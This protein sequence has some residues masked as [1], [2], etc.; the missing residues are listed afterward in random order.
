M[1]NVMRMQLLTLQSEPPDSDQCYS[2]NG[3]PIIEAH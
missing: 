2:Y 1:R 3:D